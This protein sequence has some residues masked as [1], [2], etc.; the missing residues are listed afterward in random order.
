MKTSE[1]KLPYTSTGHPLLVLL[2]HL[3]SFQQ[4]FNYFPTSSTF[5]LLKVNFDLRELHVFEYKGGAR[6]V[7]K[8]GI[9]ALLP[10]NGC[11]AN[12]HVVDSHKCNQRAHI[13][14]S[15]EESIGN[16]REGRV[17]QWGP[18]PPPATLPGLLPLKHIQG[19]SQAFH[20]IRCCWASHGN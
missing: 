3:T 10:G 20:S 5:F 8:D 15:A 2:F 11:A 13:W 12:G 19:H 1:G 6:K 4:S 18:Y 7:L 17:R 9:C 14:F 16:L